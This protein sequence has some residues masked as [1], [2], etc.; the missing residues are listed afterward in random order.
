MKHSTSAILTAALSG[1]PLHAQEAQPPQLRI[2]KTLFLPGGH[3]HSLCYSPDGRLL[4]SGGQE[5]DVTLLD[6]ETGELRHRLEA[7]DHWIGGLVFSPD[8]RQLA[9]LG[10]ELSLWRTDSGQRI[11]TTPADGPSALSWSADGKRIACMLDNRE[12]A[13]LDPAGLR[14]IRSFRVPDG[15]AADTLALSPDGRRLAVG[16][17]AGKTYIFATA[18]GKLLDTIAGESWVQGLSY[19]EDG[20]LLRAYWDGDYQ[21]LDG[22]PGRITS[23]KSIWALTAQPDGRRCALRTNKGVVIMAVGRAPIV[24]D[25]LGPVALHPD[26]ERWARA[27]K[28]AVE[29]HQG[30]R[31]LR[32]FSARHYKRPREAVISGDARFVAALDQDRRLRVLAVADGRAIPGPQGEG[33][34]T[35]LQHRGGP[36]LLI[37]RGL[38]LGYWLPVAARK[39][40]A[41]SCRLIRKIKLSPGDE[42]V[43][44]LAGR[45]SSNGRYLAAD[46]VY[47]LQRPDAAPRMIDREHVSSILS[48]ADGS[49]VA[50]RFTLASSIP[51][52]GLGE[53]FV[54]GPGAEL[55]YHERLS[56]MTRDMDANRRGDRLAFVL[57]REV[58]LVDPRRGK[59]IWRRPRGWRM[60]RFV[61]DAT[62]LGLGPAGR[63]EWLPLTG[64]A[65]GPELELGMEAYAFELSADGRHGVARGRDRL[66]VFEIQR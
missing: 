36:E 20:R 30:R 53:V 54:R 5:G 55:R 8:G 7:S 37:A 14:R 60:A 19:L 49:W 3:S 10:R 26:G 21:L 42:D 58:L 13:I 16:K 63:L 27:M 46:R 23:A 28:D 65:T 41:G 34:D 9:V 52:T 12:A 50:G 18:T 57:W 38:E 43:T 22:Q 31:Q 59:K 45:L 51:G 17:R 48:S 56:Q 47:D 66:L 24:L 40:R 6:S 4:A 29:V 1:L 35:P 39:G 25:G 33:W 62:L 15:T 61:D 64:K 44:A 2:V 11:A 32:R